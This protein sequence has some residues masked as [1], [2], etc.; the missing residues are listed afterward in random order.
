VAQNSLYPGFVKL[1]YQSNGHD[2]QMILPV[3]PFQDFTG[4]WTLEEKGVPAGEAFENAMEDLSTALKPLFPTSATILFA[5]L[6]TMDS[7][8]ADPQYRTTREL[9][10][11]GT[12]SGAAV[13]NSQAVITFRTTN[14][15]IARI[16]I[17]EGRNAVNVEA[18]PPTFTGLTD[19]VAFSAY[20]TGSGS[21]IYG[22]D[23]GELLTPIRALSKTNDALRKKFILDS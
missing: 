18:Y 11:A 4:N 19:F 7:P 12:G 17:M 23:G 1:K 13:A 3:K 6:W 2:H 22:R 5:E 10:D 8:T 20:A 21:P 9:N 16:Y 14:G 15:G